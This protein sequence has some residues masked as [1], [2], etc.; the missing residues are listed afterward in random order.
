MGTSVCFRGICSFKYAKTFCHTCD[1]IISPYLD[2]REKNGRVKLFFYSFF[3]S[4]TLCTTL[5]DL[6]ADWTQAAILLSYYKEESCKWLEIFSVEQISTTASEE[7]L[8]KYCRLIYM[9]SHSKTVS[10]Y[11]CLFLR[12]HPQVTQ[13]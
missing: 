4:S 11:T 10:F 3:C 2:A 8:Y 6:S 12:N 9:N 5:D 1:L 7:G 13:M